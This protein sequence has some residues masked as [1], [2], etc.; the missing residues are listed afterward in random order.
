MNKKLR[1]GDNLYYFLIG[2]LGLVDLVLQFWLRGKGIGILNRGFSF[3]MGAGRGLILIFLIGGLLV[4][5]WR[6][7]KNRPDR[8]WFLVLWGGTVN[9]IV[10]VMGEG[11]WDYIQLPLM[12]FRNNLSDILICFG[13]IL[14]IWRE[15]KR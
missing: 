4:W 6:L 2:I 7:F 1:V 13:V 8:A 15:W 3:G 10:R 14:L 11:V 9:F 5:G 12:P